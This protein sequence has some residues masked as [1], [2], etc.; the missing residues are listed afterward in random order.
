MGAVASDHGNCTTC[1][2]DSSTRLTHIRQF[3]KSDFGNFRPCLHGIQIEVSYIE[4]HTDRSCFYGMLFFILWWFSSWVLSCRFRWLAQMDHLTCPTENSIRTSGIPKLPGNDSTFSLTKT[5]WKS[6]PK[7]VDTVDLWTFWWQ[8]V[9]LC[10]HVQKKYRVAVNVASLGGEELRVWK[11]AGE[12]WWQ[13]QFEVS[14]TSFLRI[15]TISEGNTCIS[16]QWFSLGKVF[17]FLFC[18]GRHFF[19]SGFS[20]LMRYAICIC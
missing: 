10:Q 14:A 11:T 16:G 15:V 6:H 7:W 18:W 12:V 5:L 17:L 19:V 9:N 13:L 3:Q 4:N 1:W 2:Y 20:G 8:V